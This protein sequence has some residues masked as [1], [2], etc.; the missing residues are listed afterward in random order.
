LKSEV[1]GVMVMWWFGVFWVVGKRWV[2]IEGGLA[3]YW[4]SGME[5][6]SP[7][8]YSNCCL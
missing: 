4:I 8:V 3:G 2:C 1:V 6:C 5:H 7:S